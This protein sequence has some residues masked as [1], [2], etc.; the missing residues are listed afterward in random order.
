MT[1]ATLFRIEGLL[2]LVLAPFA[3]L[4][5]GGGGLWRRVGSYCLGN[6]FLA[7]AALVVLAWRYLVRCFSSEQKQVKLGEGGAGIGLYM[8]YN[9]VSSFVINV[10]SGKRTEVIGLC[11]MDRS[12]GQAQADT[13]RSFC[14]FHER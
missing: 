12:S 2:F 13:L 11:Q 4:F 7:L 14:Y 10:A 3:L 9:A 6:V 8:A 5:C 1:F